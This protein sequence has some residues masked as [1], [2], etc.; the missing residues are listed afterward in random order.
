MMSNPSARKFEQG[1]NQAAGSAVASAPSARTIVK[2]GPTRAVYEK[3]AI[4]AILDEAFICHVGFVYQGTPRVI[5]CVFARKDDVLYLHGS[6]ANR[7][8]RSIAEGEVCVTVTLLD[9]LVLARAAFHNSVNYRSVVVYGRG[10]VVTDPA[11]RQEALRLTVEHAIPGRWPDV[12]PPNREEDLRTLVVRV[13]LDEASAKIRMGDPVD[14]D[15]DHALDC[16]AGVIPLRTAAQPP[17]DDGLLR[18]EIAP[19][20]YAVEYRRPTR[21]D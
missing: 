10:E 21:G 5:P 8:L 4:H 17:I 12:R 20:G 7:M 6:T 13:P 11:E 18:A 2:R 1:S 19:P 16:W 3:R 14:D 15:E 9:G